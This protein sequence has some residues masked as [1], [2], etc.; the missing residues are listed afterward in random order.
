MKLGTMPNM[1]RVGVVPGTREL[2]FYPW[3]YIAVYKIA[4]DSVRII[5]IRHV[6]QEWP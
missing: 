5:R 3:P 2:I 1:G 4:G 6:P